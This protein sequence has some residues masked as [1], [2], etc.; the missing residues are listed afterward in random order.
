[1]VQ[2]FITHFILFHYLYVMQSV[3]ELNLILHNNNTCLNN[4]CCPL[5][6]SLLGTLYC[7]TLTLA[8]FEPFC[9]AHLN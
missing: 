3:Y 2:C 7:A 8:L 4:Q 9:T 6:G 1:M 5:Q